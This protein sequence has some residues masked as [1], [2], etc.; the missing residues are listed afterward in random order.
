M[1]KSKIS[2]MD[3]KE[4]I[5]ITGAGGFI[6]FHICKELLKNNLS[7]IG[8]DNINSYY[9]INLKKNRIKN[10]KT[11]TNSKNC[12]FT[13]FQENLEDF[14][15]LE[16]VFNKYNPKVVIHLAAQAGVRY[17]LKNPNAYI[18][19]NI[20]GFINILECCR[21]YPVKNL[22]YASSS[23]VYGGNIKTP[24]SESDSV[25]HPVSLYAATKKANELMAHT[26]SHLYK[27]PS[28]GL[29]F[30][31]VYGPWGRPDM[32]P[33]LFTKS[34]INDEPINIYNY[35]KMYRD[36]TYISDIIEIIIRLIDK[37][38]K[39]NKKYLNIQPEPYLSWAPYQIFNIGNSNPIDLEKFIYTLEIELDKTAIKNYIE[40]QPGEVEKTFA[41][42]SLI[43]KIT[44]FKPNTSIELGIKKFVQWYKNYYI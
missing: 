26:Y 11:F 44:G 6:G 20:L 35:G 24:F 27:I 17:S 15:S 7:I 12:S 5:L 19:S 38:P 28:I 9:D 29:R 43:T 18:N 41:D 10:L 2:F 25:D 13:F 14:K 23:S 31:T 36:F 40:I 32:A 37:P 34:I 16:A 1:E 22:I 33:M 3:S 8:F 4:S 39:E 42:T 30:F 21:K